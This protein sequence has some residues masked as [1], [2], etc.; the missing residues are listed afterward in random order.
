MMKENQ[1][2]LYTKAYNH[3]KNLKNIGFD[4]H[5]EDVLLKKTMM[6]R[7]FANPNVAGFLRHIN[8][9]MVNNIDAVKILQ[10]F[11]NYTVKKNDMDTR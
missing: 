4:Y 5:E 6:P 9:V 2:N 10:N 8:N 3:G 1:T 7:L 11:I